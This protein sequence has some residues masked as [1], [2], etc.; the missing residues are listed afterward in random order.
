[1]WGNTAVTG[2]ILSDSKPSAGY[3]WPESAPNTDT[4][5]L[6][7]LLTDTREHLL[8]ACATYSEFDNEKFQN[9]SKTGNLLEDAITFLNHHA[10]QFNS[11]R[12]FANSERVRKSINSS[13]ASKSPLRIVIPI[14]CIIGNWAKRIDPTTV[15]FAEECT[16]RSLQNIAHMYQ[17]TVG[18]RLK[19]EIIADA[20]F[21]TRPFGSDPTFA[22]GYLAGLKNYVIS[23]N[24]DAL[25]IHDMSDIPAGKLCEFEKE[26]IRVRSILSHDPTYGLEA[27]EA[28][29]WIESMSKCITTRDL[30]ASYEE[31]KDT[32]KNGN[33]KSKFGQEV[34]RR[35]ER[36]FVDYRA[37]KYALSALD[38]E[39][40][41]FPDSIRATI[42]HKKLDVMGLRVY[43]RY[44]LGS[45]LLPYHGVALIS[46][47]DEGGYQMQV[48]P[49]ISMVDRDEYTRYITNDGFTD[50]YLTKALNVVQS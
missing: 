50:L 5:K 12:R 47:N 36:A 42:H 17:N 25:T 23:K 34:L 18:L 26:Y 24:L 11:K 31:V 33:F 1:M 20:T 13:I 3:D 29:S 16:L 22:A 30:G 32:F 39:D 28:Q 10:F 46:S 45:R 41:H 43:P 27:R 49:E 37:L 48:L 40:T 21:Y 9:L 8:Q 19:F 6:E 35:T 4:S 15:T 44:K 2:E 38:W 14:F 7:T